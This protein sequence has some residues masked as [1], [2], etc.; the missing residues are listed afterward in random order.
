MTQILKS[1]AQN[2][3]FLLVLLKMGLMFGQSETVKK[4]VVI[5]PG[6]G[7]IDS[8]A[9]G[10]GIQE[11]DITLSIAKEVL[12]LNKTLFENEVEI[13]LTRSTD[14]L[15]A[16]SER[17]HLAKALRADVFISIHCNAAYQ[18]ARGIEVFIP[19]GSDALLFSSFEL[20][21]HI[22]MIYQDKLGFESR[23]IKSANFAVLRNASRFYPAILLEVG[24][25]SHRD[26]ALYFSSSQ[27]ITALALGLLE[28][29]Y[30][31]QN[32]KL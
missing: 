21:S 6:H 12:R 2:V 1:K 3:I 23:G 16:L 29:L 31:H 25:M 9:I 14:T 26:E 11:K 20:A 5:D 27:N 4:I 7:G 28:G 32:L 30:K 18:N 15:I 24:F 10:F 19:N 13:Y 22:A 8:G 17:S